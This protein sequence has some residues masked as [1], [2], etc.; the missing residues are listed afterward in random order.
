MQIEPQMAHQYYSW[1]LCSFTE[2]SKCDPPCTGNKVCQNYSGAPE[3]V[4]PEGFIGEDGC[5][6]MLGS[7]SKVLLHDHIPLG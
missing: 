7:L 4:C 6:G 2:E 5:I 3:C 1:H